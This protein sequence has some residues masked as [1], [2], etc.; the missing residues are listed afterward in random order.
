MT[1]PKEIFD[2]ERDIPPNG[3]SPVLLSG[4]NEWRFRLP[5]TLCICIFGVVANMVNVVVLARP[6]MLR[7]ATVN[8][9]LLGMSFAQLMLIVNCV[10]GV[11]HETAVL[12]V[13]SIQL[14]FLE[15]LHSVS[16]LY[17]EVGHYYCHVNG[18]MTLH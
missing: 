14:Y 5:L 10:Y 8:V 12:T 18:F 16:N 3:T 4:I 9:L 7:W 13:A 1:F 17:L 2:F 6:T 11:C 15:W